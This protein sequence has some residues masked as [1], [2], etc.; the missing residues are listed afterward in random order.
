LAPSPPPFLSFPIVWLCTLSLDPLMSLAH[1]LF[2]API[3][4]QPKP[5]RLP[6][7]PLSFPHTRSAAGSLHLL[8]S[9]LLC[10]HNSSYSS[11]LNSVSNVV[12]R[13]V[14]P[15]FHFREREGAGLLSIVHYATLVP[16][17]IPFPHIFCKGLFF[18]N[19]PKQTHGSKSFTL[20]STN[21]LA[22]YLPLVPFESAF[23]HCDV[24]PGLFC[25]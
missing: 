18:C 4:D 16:Q 10:P 22:F 17:T 11:V 25:C 23:Y 20:V 5:L 8:L 21:A 1:D 12:D 13:S 14:S 7:L 6:C 19:C 3:V 9:F 24:S 15:L 2:F